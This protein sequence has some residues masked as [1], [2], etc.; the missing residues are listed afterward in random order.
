MVAW[1]QSQAPDDRRSTHSSGRHDAVACTGGTVGSSSTE[2]PGACRAGG[3]TPASPEKFAV[4]EAL[5]WCC[6]PTLIVGRVV[7]HIL[8]S[9]Y[10]E[11]ESVIH[12]L[13]VSCRRFVVKFGF[14]KL[15]QHA[16]PTVAG[17]FFANVG[18]WQPRTLL[19]TDQ[20]DR[21]REDRDLTHRF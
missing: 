7:A 4:L 13:A 17:F 1:P 2:L 10:P 11:F 14:E 5:P 15:I 12:T 18:F 16:K 3:E 19:A 8:L 6:P 21:Q 20:L 9:Q